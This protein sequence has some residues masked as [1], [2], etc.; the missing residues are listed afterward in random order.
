M[1]EV[2]KPITYQGW[3]DLYEISSLG[4]LRNRKTQEIR[5]LCV[6]N[7]GY[8]YCTINRNGKTKWIS[9]HRAVALV[10]IDNP[11]GLPCVNHK[12]ENKFN[13]NVENLEW[14]DWRYNCNYGTGRQRAIAKFGKHKGKVPV[15]QYSKEGKLIAKYES[16]AEAS[17]QSGVNMTSLRKAAY[18]EQKRRSAGGYIWRL[19]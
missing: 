2:W 19:V 1:K 11:S 13:N 12:D 18:G 7:A 14:C 16:I 15:A 6:D 4:R 17:R 3:E 9:I 10:F 5:K 8:L